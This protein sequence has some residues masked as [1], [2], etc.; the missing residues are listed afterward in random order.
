MMNEC[1]SCDL[2]LEV[3]VFLVKGMWQLEIGWI[4]NYGCR[5]QLKWDCPTCNIRLL[6]IIRVGGSRCSRSS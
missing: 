5:F 2:V 1:V 6:G 3:D 4:H